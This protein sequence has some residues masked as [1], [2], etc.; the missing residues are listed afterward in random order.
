MLNKG[1]KGDLYRSLTGAE[2][3][4]GVTTRPADWCGRFPVHGLA[5]CVRGFS[6]IRFMR[7]P[8]FRNGDT[9]LALPPSPT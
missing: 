8:L 5:A 7:G 9:L 3:G 6:A 4:S 1:A 2:L